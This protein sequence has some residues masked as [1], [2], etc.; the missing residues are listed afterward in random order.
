MSML[1]KILECGIVHAISNNGK[2]TFIV[3]HA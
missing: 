2:I 3:I 1:Q